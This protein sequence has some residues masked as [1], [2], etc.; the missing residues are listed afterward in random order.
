MGI[1]SMATSLRRN[2]ARYST[3]QRKEGREGFGDRLHLAKPC[4]HEELTH[5]KA[6]RHGGTHLSALPGM[7]ETPGPL[8][9]KGRPAWQNLQAPFSERL[10]LK[11]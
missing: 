11:K 9:L 6:V 3:A 10:C 2:E 7:T 8:E 1:L 4:K 5:T